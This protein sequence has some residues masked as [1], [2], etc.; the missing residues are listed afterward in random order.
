MKKFNP[1]NYCFGQ[2]ENVIFKNILAHL[3]FFVLPIMK[4]FAL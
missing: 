1:P 4:L 3:K 2:K